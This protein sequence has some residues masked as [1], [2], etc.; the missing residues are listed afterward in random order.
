MKG[1]FYTYLYYFFTFIEKRLSLGAKQKFILL[2]Y[3]IIKA[4]DKR[5]KNIAFRNLDFIYENRLTDKEKKEIVDS[6]YKNLVTN[7]FEFLRYQNSNKSEILNDIEFENIESIKKIKD[8]GVIFVAAHYG[9]WELIT[10]ASSLELNINITVVGRKLGIEKL[11]SELKRSRERFGVRIVDKSGASRELIK[12]LKNGECIGI[13]TDQ[14]S[15]FKNG[16][17]VEFLGKN[18]LYHNIASTLARK[19]QTPIVPI[20]IKNIEN[21]RKKI[22]FLEPIYSNPKCNLNSDIKNLTQAQANAM[23]SYIL[24]E[25]KDWFWFHRRW[26]STH[27]HTYK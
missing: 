12:A 19:F 8:R 9:N 2:I 15:N 4:L 20:Y 27:P 1:F 26:K 24:E 3:N 18:S 5:R 6:G 21:N 17:E 14:N 11:D 16:S 10:L 23:Q 7:F 25:P 13:L 22:V